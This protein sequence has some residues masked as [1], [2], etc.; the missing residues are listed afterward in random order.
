MVC[1]QF[2]QAVDFYLC[3]EQQAHLDDICRLAAQGSSNESDG[4]LLGYALEGVRLSGPPGFCREASDADAFT[5]DDGS[6]VRIRSGDRVFVSFDAAARDP[7]HF[8]DPDA[9][10][11]RR[12]VGAYVHYGAEP[13]T[14][15]GTEVS[16]VALVELFR[17][18]FRKKGLRR[19][20]GPQGRLK[21]VAGPG[22]Y[23][24]FMTEDWGDFSPFPTSLKVMWDE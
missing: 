11:P 14:R 5:E 20:P 9:V 7:T 1:A 2:A 18:V 22:G 24:V 19:V 10:N 4:L 15:L 16:Q 17:A 13:L 21:R 3:P 12:P 6:Q 23:S 8:P